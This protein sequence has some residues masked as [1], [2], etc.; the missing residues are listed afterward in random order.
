MGREDEVRDLFDDHYDQVVR[1]AFLIVQDWGRAEE[2]AQDAFV[3]LLR[4]WG[5][6]SGHDVP[7]AWVRRVAVRLAVRS[8]RR[9][10]RA[11]PP[12]ALWALDR[13]D[14]CAS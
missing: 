5:R 4:Y 11:T 7:A 10:P 1:T 2:I 3:Q 6:V 13:A 9:A 14:T 8:V 12:A